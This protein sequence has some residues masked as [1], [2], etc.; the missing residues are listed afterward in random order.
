[1]VGMA[2]LVAR[3]GAMEDPVEM[4][5]AV[6]GTGPVEVAGLAGLVA[7]TVVME[8]VGVWANKGLVV[9][10]AAT[11]ALGAQAEAAAAMAERAGAAEKVA[12]KAGTAVMGE[13]VVRAAREEETEVTV[14]AAEML[15]EATVMAVTA[16]TAAMPAARA[17]APETA[18]VAETAVQA[19]AMG[20][21]GA[22]AAVAARGRR[23]PPK[24]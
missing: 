20:V 18:A 23:R 21:R 13:M 19:A 4:G 10:P 5:D 6:P 2:V 3:M 16:A 12:A 22:R 24:P 11:G 17:V 7:Q 8:A 14:V 15:A 9:G 1:M